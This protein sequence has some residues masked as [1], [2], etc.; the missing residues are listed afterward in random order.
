M[1]RRGLL[2]LLLLSGCLDE[3]NSAGGRCAIDNAE[4][5]I[6]TA[7]IEGRYL[8]LNISRG[9]GCGPHDFTLVWP[10]SFGASDP[11]VTTL[12]LEHDGH[13][14]LCAALITQ[15]LYFD[16]TTLDDLLAA[17]GA[18]RALINLQGYTGPLM[19]TAGQ[20]DAP[21]NADVQLLQRDC[22]R[23]P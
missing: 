19:Y 5:T 21:P 8:H 14:D 12:V 4:T 6:N 1:L 16:L 17:G 15:D 18:T 22:D 13:G 23:R 7:A 9:G 20:P 3:G 11:P 2:S 10:E